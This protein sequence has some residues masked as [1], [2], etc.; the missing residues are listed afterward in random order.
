[1]RNVFFC[2]LIG[3][4]FWGCSDENPSSSFA[5]N[6]SCSAIET[7]SSSIE[8]VESSPDIA[9]SSSSNEVSTS[10]SEI[11]SS[12]LEQ[13]SSSIYVSHG[14]MTD[15]RDGQIY[16]TVTIG[17]QT[18]MAENLNYAYP[19]SLKGLDS[20]SYCYNND[21]ENCIKYG[22]LYTWAAA[23][24]SLTHYAEFKKYL[25]AHTEAFYHK[26]QINWRNSILPD[27]RDFSVPGSCPKNWHIPSVNEWNSL[28][29]LV[30]DLIIDKK[31]AEGI[32]DGIDGINA[33]RFSFQ[34]EE[35]GK[36]TCFWTPVQG[37]MLL[38]D[39]EP[40]TYFELASAFCFFSEIK[41]VSYREGFDKNEALFVRCVKDSTEAE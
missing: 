14:V 41:D 22:R 12:S 9:K 27:E 24:D 26:N 28:F 36:R 37:T 2:L 32:F 38:I 17:N 19:L 15:K 10:S 29:E 6:S 13:S 40:A 5:E 31:S 18:W 4:L 1:M 7:F 35:I 34:T 25:D 23:V 33:F 39:I 30:N 20:A 11:S 16:K 3:I 8:N 21:P